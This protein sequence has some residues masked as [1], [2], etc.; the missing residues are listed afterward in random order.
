MRLATYLTQNGISDADFAKRI[1]VERQSV[2]RYKTGERYPDRV[3]LVA[4]HRATDG[5]VTAND[6][7]YPGLVEKAEAAQ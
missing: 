6:F 5:A 4:I 3:T 1:G 2:Y 7:A